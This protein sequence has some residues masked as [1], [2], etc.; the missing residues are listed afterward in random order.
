MKRETAAF[1]FPLPPAF[2]TPFALARLPTAQAYDPT[3]RQPLPEQLLL[4]LN[5]ELELLGPTDVEEL[6]LDFP[7]LLFM[8]IREGSTLMHMCVMTRLHSPATQDAA[9]ILPK[10]RWL[11]HVPRMCSGVPRPG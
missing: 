7:G 11:D 4:Q 5:P 9:D 8:P 6:V 10:R 2:S 1:H 3:Y